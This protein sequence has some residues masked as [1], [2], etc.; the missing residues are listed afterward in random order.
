[1]RM[2][3]KLAILVSGKSQREIAAEASVQESRLSAIVR[4]W[5]VPNAR[6]RTA[7]STVLRTPPEQL[8]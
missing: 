7:L 3:L 8:F 6:E 5:T 2:P 4:G 1:M